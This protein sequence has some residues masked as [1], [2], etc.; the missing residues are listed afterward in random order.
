MKSTN[1]SPWARYEP[2][3]D[4][5]WDLRKV[6]HLHRRAGFGATRAELLRD[7]EAGSEASVNRFFQ[8]SPLPPGENEAI[9]AL[10]QTAQTSANLDLLKVCWLNRILQGTDPLREKLTL[11][12]HG[13]FAT[14]HKKVES[15]S[16]MDRQNETLRT[17]A[18]GGFAAFLEAMADDPAMLVWLDGGTSK[19]NKPNEN[20]AR[21]FLELFTLG[22]GHYSE[23]DVREAARAFTGWVR[24]DSRGGFQETPVFVREPAQI[25]DG[26]KTFLGLNGRWGP[27]DIVRITLERPE[28]S[29]F[30][31]RKLYRFLVSEFDVPGPDLIEPLAEV[32]KR[33]QFD[34]GPI[35]GII[36][37]SRH[38]YS[39]ASYRQRIKSPVEFS[40]GLIRTLEVPRAAINPLALSAACDAQGQELFAPPNVEGWVGGST[41]INSGTLLERTNWAADVV[42]GRAEY[43]LPPFDPRVWA[44]RA[45]LPAD[46]TIGAF[47]DLLL[48]GD[49]SDEAR[50]LVL[51]A[52][53]DGTADGLRKGLQRLTNCP[54]YQ[55]A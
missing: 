21:E 38:F 29:L 30:L 48:Q 31:A 5:P 23:R 32:V 22:A 14:S 6:A 20:F 7:V 17:H 24:Q 39:R 18:L 34:I 1:A 25:D 44:A 12:W 54:E 9:A 42:W 27:S 3:A 41:W 19:K 52:G 49:V 45:M 28:A 47:L 35:V 36:L 16:L 11:F 51:D 43:G 55:L 15:V 33:N 2:S 50:R 53:R 13:H 40:A 8:A 37:R 10:R 4:D 26:P 46:L